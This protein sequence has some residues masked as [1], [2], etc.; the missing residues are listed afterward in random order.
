MSPIGA[1]APWKESMSRS[2]SRIERRL[3]GRPRRPTATSSVHHATVSRVEHHKAAS[4]D[5]SSTGYI[6]VESSG[7]HRVRHDDRGAGK[8]LWMAW[9]PP[10]SPSDLIPAADHH[11]GA[12]GGAQRVHR[13]AQAY[14][15]GA[16][17]EGRSRRTCAL[18]LCHCS[19]DFDQELRGSGRARATV[20]TGGCMRRGALLP[21]SLTQLPTATYSLTTPCAAAWLLEYQREAGQGR[22]GE[23]DNSVKPRQGQPR[24]F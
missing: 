9:A 4:R 19:G 21:H 22:I 18:A 3:R 8:I 13:R 15:T 10:D 14:R 17:G 11:V 20:C 1:L 12:G 23:N 6:F 24:S 16:G 5:E 7:D 2:A